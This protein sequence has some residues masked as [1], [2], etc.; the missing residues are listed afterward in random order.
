MS[1][2]LFGGV[3]A[4]A[5]KLGDTWSWDGTNWTPV[6]S[7]Q[8]PTPRA[9]HAM[10]TLGKKVVLFGGEDATGL[11]NDTWEW[12]G[13]NWSPKLPAT[14]PPAR[15]RHAMAVWHARIVLFGGTGAAGALN[16]TWEW[17]GTTWAPMTAPTSPSKRAQHSMA[18]HS[19][20]VV[21]FGGSTPAD[22]WIY[23]SGLDAG[24]TCANS[25]DCALGHC[26]D[27]FC[28]DTACD[29]QCESCNQTGKLGTCTAV[30]GTPATGRPVCAGAVSCTSSCDA[31]DDACAPSC[32]AGTDPCR[33]Q[34]DGVNRVS[35][36]YPAETFVCVQAACVNAEEIQP[37]LCSGNGMCSAPKKIACGDYKCEGLKCKTTCTTT[38]D[39]TTGAECKNQKCEVPKPE[40]GVASDAAP[41]D[42]A[43]SAIVDAAVDTG[44]PAPA[45]ASK[46]CGCR[47]VGASSS[48]MSAW[49]LIGAAL[50][51]R[52]RTARQKFA[53][54]H[55]EGTPT[56]AR[57][58][59]PH[60]LP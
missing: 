4:T 21:L 38:A 6:A 12:D 55:S 10:V 41:E 60:G 9:D 2:L 43:P 45:P 14:S 27:A 15:A 33:G 56:H 51:L 58:G 37:A 35:C 32:D 36:T 17:D 34:C 39:C 53:V 18:P 46:N 19:S 54:V 26:V 40:G 7:A 23:H 3:S 22:T 49:L 25:S 57:T 44:Q 24:S 5:Q 28:C 42:D 50:I 30:K 13:T 16:D 59:S 29:G 20:G 48:S 8:S 11:L 1:A 47:T 52:K 31:G